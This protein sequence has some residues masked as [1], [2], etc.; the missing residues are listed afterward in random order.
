MFKKLIFLF[1]KCFMVILLVVFIIV[2][3]LFLVWKYFCVNL[4]VG[5]WIVFGVLNVRL[6]IFLKFR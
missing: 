4:S 1:K 5:K 6:F 3:V 2:V